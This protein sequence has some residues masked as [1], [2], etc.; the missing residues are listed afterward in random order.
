MLS[1]FTRSS[2]W[3]FSKYILNDLRLYSTLVGGHGSKIVLRSLCWYVTRN[4]CGFWTF[5]SVCVDRPRD[6]PE[7][8]FACVVKWATQSVVM[9]PCSLLY[10]HQ[11]FRGTYWLHLQ[12]RILRQ[13]LVPIRWYI[14]TRQHGVVALVFR[15]REV[16][17]S[18]IGSET[19]CSDRY[20]CPSRQ[21]SD[22]ALN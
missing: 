13:F 1:F 21:I 18:D 5:T 20:L 22:S 9:T 12:G 8:G 14:P 19:G 4:R 2:K 16:P 7:A 11:R 3:T 10:G 6:F 15:I 17:V